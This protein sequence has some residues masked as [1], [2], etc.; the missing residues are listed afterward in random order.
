MKLLALSVCLLATIMITRASN[1][2]NLATHG[3]EPSKAS[4]LKQECY[5][6]THLTSEELISQ[7][8]MKNNTYKL[9]PEKARKNGCFAACILQKRELI[10]DGVIQKEKLY[11][12][13]AHANLRPDVRAAI[14]RAVDRCVKEV[15][16]N[17]DL[18]DKSLE[19]LVCFW[20]SFH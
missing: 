7:E 19:L 20:K 12:K 8:E 14:Y 6:E 5:D 2:E 13:E 10:V 17:P 11:A 16:T 15:E 9:N 1:L 3:E 4:T 18:C